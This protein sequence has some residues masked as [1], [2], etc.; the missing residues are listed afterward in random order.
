[1][2]MYASTGPGTLS[3]SSLFWTRLQALQRDALFVWGRRDKLV[4][5]AFARHVA[6]A[7]PH[8][9]HLELDCGHVPQVERPRQT[10]AAVA[11]FLS[12]PE[13]AP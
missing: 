13:D 5:I 3:T 6:D 2:R 7:L 8:A 1:M 9:Q 11:S 4:P 12:V 10:H